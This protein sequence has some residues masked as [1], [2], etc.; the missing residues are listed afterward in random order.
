MGHIIA[1]LAGGA[2]AGAVT[3]F[4]FLRAR[5]RKGAEAEDD[6]AGRARRT[7]QLAT[8]GSLAGALIHEI[9]NPLN[10]LSLNLQ[11]LAEDWRDA[12]GQKERRALKRIRLLQAETDRLAS[13]LDDFMDLVRGHPLMP[14]ECDVNKIV[15]EAITFVRPELESNCIEIRSSYGRL[16]PSRLDANLMKQALLNLILNAEQAMSDDHPREIIIRTV[17][18]DDSVR[19]DVIDTGRGI[20][21]ENVKKIFDAFYSTR[22]GGT[23]LGLSTT[24]RIVEEHGGRITVHSDQ[25]RGTCFTITLP[26]GGPPE[27]LHEQGGAAGASGGTSHG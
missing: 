18:E 27:V 16:P 3:A 22:K 24:R 11:L 23:G 14:S 4:A 19:I 5:R 13:I 15:D 10:T 1:F 6:A 21:A 20:P 25:G 12:G 17:P 8:A 26:V 9:K 7:E 2:V